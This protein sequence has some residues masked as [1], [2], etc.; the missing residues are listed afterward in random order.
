MQTVFGI[1]LRLFVIAAGLVFAA[2]LAVV[3]AAVLAFW[4]LRAGWA[5]LTGR[6][7]SPFVVRVDPRGGFDRMYRR[8]SAP[9]RAPRASAAGA[10]RVVGDV[11]D[12]EPK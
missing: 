8:A 1:L 12:V 10:G 9:G 4:L 7:V 3:F 2:S 6:P 5:R 11:T